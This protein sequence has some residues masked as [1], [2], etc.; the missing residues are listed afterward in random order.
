MPVRRLV[1]SG[2]LTATAFPALLVV[3]AVL[4]R[5]TLPDDDYVPPQPGV[6]VF[7]A[8][9]DP[10]L[11]FVVMGDSTAAGRG[12]DYDAGIAVGSARSLAAR[13]RRVTLTNL[14]VSG[15]THADVRAS[16]LDGAVRA[17]PDLVVL[18]AGANDVTAR[19]GPVFRRDRNLFAADGYHPSAAGYA[20]W[21][22]VL[23]EAYAAA[24]REPSR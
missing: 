13:G 10:P 20:V 9:G 14:A 2:I 24:L 1:L 22:P 8:A 11:A 4:A 6:R 19:T 18:S 3:Q 17:R 7:G 23:R 12:A 16:Q 15:A 21:L 5:L